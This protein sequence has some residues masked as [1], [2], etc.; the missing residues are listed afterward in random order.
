MGPQ[1][2][3]TGEKEATMVHFSQSL[4]TQINHF[5]LLLLPHCQPVPNATGGAVILLMYVHG[6]YALQRTGV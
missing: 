1:A 4:D 5:A 6:R 3:F 2:P